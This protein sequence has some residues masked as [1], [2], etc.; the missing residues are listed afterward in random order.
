[1]RVRRARARPRLVLG[2]A[3]DAIDTERSSPMPVDGWPSQARTHTCARLGGARASSLAE[4]VSCASVGL[5]LSNVRAS[6]SGSGLDLVRRQHHARARD[7]GVIFGGVFG[8]CSG[9]ISFQVRVRGS[10]EN[11]TRAHLHLPCSTFPN[12]IF[13]QHRLPG[14]RPPIRITPRT[15]FGS[16]PHTRTSSIGRTVN[17]LPSIIVARVR[18]RASPTQPHWHNTLVSV[19]PS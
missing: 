11:I 16:H 8:F 19:G 7:V 12:D 6:G 9:S 4:L 10:G 17:V 5:S 1:M 13:P 2:S 18:G 3:R 14:P 15:R